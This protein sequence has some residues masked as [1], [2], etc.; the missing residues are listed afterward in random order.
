MTFLLVLQNWKEYDVRKLALQEDPRQFRCSSKWEMEFLQEKILSIY[1]FLSR[2][3]IK[4][5]IEKTC[6]K[7][8]KCVDRV[9]F[10]KE[11]LAEITDDTDR[12]IVL[13]KTGVR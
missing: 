12:T 2:E 6:R 10:V 13:K 1:G 8:N 3:V 5:A 7:R 9:G 11:V 4:D